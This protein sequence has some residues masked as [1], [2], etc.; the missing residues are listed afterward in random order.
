LTSSLIR[1]SSSISPLSLSETRLKFN[2]CMDER[3]LH[4]GK[5]NNPLLVKGEDMVVEI[6]VTKRDE[7]RN[8]GPHKASAYFKHGWHIDRRAAQSRLRGDQ[9]TSLEQHSKTLESVHCRHHIYVSVTPHR[10]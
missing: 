6:D 1:L 9:P 7:D 2:S 3:R 8:E 5:L 4:K 10:T